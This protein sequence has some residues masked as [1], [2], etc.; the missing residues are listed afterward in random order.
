MEDYKYILAALVIPVMYIAGKHNLIAQLC[1]MLEEKATKTDVADTNV[2]KWIPC[3]EGVPEELHMSLVTLENG[4]VCLGVYRPESNEWLT[5][6]CEGEIHY[7]TSHKVIAW[8][9]LPEPYKGE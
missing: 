8:Q 6:M 1:E 3:S 7:T 4:E 9:L 2:G 5:R